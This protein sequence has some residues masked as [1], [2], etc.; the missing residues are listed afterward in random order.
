M[1]W[2]AHAYHVWKLKKPARDRL[3]RMR[4]LHTSRKAHS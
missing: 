4:A 3:S 2:S 1:A